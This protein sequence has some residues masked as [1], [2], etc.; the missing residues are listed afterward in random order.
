MLRVRQQNSTSYPI[1]F[2]LADSSDH[3]TGKT[4][5]SP[6]VTVS[7]DGGAFGSP[8]GA[9]SEVAN[10]WY[11]LAGHATDRNTLGCFALHATGTGADPADALYTIVAYDPIGDAVRGT[12]GTALP[13]SGTLAVNPTL[14]ADQ[15]GVTIGTVTTLTNAP[16]DSAGVTTLL[17]RVTATRAGYLD[18]L[19]GGAVALAS[20]VVVTAAGVLAISKGVADRFR[21]EGLVP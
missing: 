19:S 1:L 13:A 14:A 18:N 8:S 10:G 17:S 20:G 4:G 7:K 9:V 3:V 2:F 11:K 6:T 21:D 15:S 12:G 16:A 5:L